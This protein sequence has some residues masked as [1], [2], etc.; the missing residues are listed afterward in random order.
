MRPSITSRSHSSCMGQ[1][2]ARMEMQV[3][4][5]AL[6]A[7]MPEIELIDPDSVKHE[8]AGSETALAPL[9]ALRLAADH[10]HSI[11]VADLGSGF[12]RKCFAL[13]GNPTGLVA[14]DS[15]ARL[16]ITCSGNENR[17]DSDGARFL[18]FLMRPEARRPK[19]E[20]WL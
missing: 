9:P 12:V 13:P 14:A 2:M 7:R 18:K 1:P 19:P 5:G 16:I 4:L 8:F 20:A 10:A 11:V 15:P 17:V 6:L 3:A